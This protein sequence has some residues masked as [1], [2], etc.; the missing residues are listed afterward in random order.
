MMK[1]FRHNKKKYF[2]KHDLFR[3]LMTHGMSLGVFKILSEFLSIQGNKYKY[4]EI[5]S[6]ISSK[7]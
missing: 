5:S 7:I 6:K 4:R 2:F 1:N 3:L